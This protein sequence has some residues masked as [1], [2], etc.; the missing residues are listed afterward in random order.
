MSAVG[1]PALSTIRKVI[2]AADMQHTHRLHSDTVSHDLSPSP[3]TNQG[4]ILALMTLCTEPF[5]RTSS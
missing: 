4:H 2:L 3:C 5:E 1:D